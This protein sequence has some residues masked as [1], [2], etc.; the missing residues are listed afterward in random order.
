MKKKKN[1]AFK[2]SYDQYGN[3]IEYIH[4]DEYKNI[5]DIKRKNI[6]SLERIK[7]S[8]KCF[9]DKVRDVIK[10]GITSNTIYARKL[11]EML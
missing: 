5:L 7:N 6:E 3:S 11:L 10:C 9:G 2:R 1:N 4:S 8:G